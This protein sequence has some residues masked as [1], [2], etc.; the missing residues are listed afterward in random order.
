[1]ETLKRSLGVAVSEPSKV[2]TG[3]EKVE[4]SPPDSSD[5][6]ALSSWIG[7]V[8]NDIKPDSEG[9][10]VAADVGYESSTHEY[11]DPEFEPDSEF[12][13]SNR[14]FEK[15]WMLVNESFTSAPLEEDPDQYVVRNAKDRRLHIHAGSNWTRVGKGWHLETIF[16]DVFNEYSSFET[17]KRYYLVDKRMTE[18]D[19]FDLISTYLSRTSSSIKEISCPIDDVTYT[20]R[21]NEQNSINKFIQEKTKAAYNTIVWP[22][23]V[24]DFSKSTRPSNRMEKGS[25]IARRDEHGREWSEIGEYWGYG[26]EELVNGKFRGKWTRISIQPSEPSK[27]RTSVKFRRKQGADSGYHCM[28]VHRWLSREDAEIIVRWCYESGIQNLTRDRARFESRLA[29][30]E[31]GKNKNRYKIL[32]HKGDDGLDNIGNGDPGTVASTAELLVPGTQ[33]PHITTASTVLIARTL[34]KTTILTTPSPL[35]TASPPFQPTHQHPQQTPIPPNPN[36]STSDGFTT[37]DI[38][39]GFTSGWASS[40][41]HT[42]Q[43]GFALKTKKKRRKKELLGTSFSKRGSTTTVTVPT[44]ML[45]ALALQISAEQNQANEDDGEWDTEPDEAQGLEVT[46]DAN[47]TEAPVSADPMAWSC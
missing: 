22:M 34:E 2:D 44:D 10:G 31:L 39:H 35:E 17:R 21:L 3:M 18:F 46:Y 9:R 45:A 29:R 16:R 1:M 43:S 19:A 38:E 23:V 6:K 26:H 12:V 11:S 8:L 32:N 13:E 4:Q 30:S 47:E 15:A 7:A 5:E 14:A 42:L 27:A 24:G 40:Y 33:K 20:E 25:I 36:P 28:I 41:S 37:T